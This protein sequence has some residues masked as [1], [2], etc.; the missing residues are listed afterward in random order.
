MTEEDT[1]ELHIPPEAEYVGTAR[2]FIAAAGRHFELSEEAV[3]DVKVAVSEVCAEAIEAGG[4]LQPLKIV[5]RPRPT[6]LH[7]EVSPSSP[8]IEA[9]TPVSAA[10]A[11]A[12]AAAA[13]PSLEHTLR[14][15]L[16]HALFPD[17]AYE[18]KR[19][20]LRLSL[21]WEVPE[22]SGDT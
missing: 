11:P 19:H 2:L 7:V 14:E 8:G 18:P 5:V 1:L 22:D 10:A 21:P 6:A 17:A 9:D 20:S 3:A 16:V 13:P 15:P 4:F 12:D